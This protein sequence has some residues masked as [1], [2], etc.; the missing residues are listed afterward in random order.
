MLGAMRDVLPI[1]CRL[2]D[3]NLEAVELDVLAVDPRDP[4]QL[5][6]LASP[7][8][9]WLHKTTEHLAG[10][11]QYACALRPAA[12]TAEQVPAS[13]H[14]NPGVSVPMRRHGQ[15]LNAFV[16]RFAF[17]LPALRARVS[18]DHPE[19]GRRRSCLARLLAAAALAAHLALDRPDAAAWSV[20]LD[21]PL[22]EDAISSQA[23]YRG[24][25]AGLP[26]ELITSLPISKA[27]E[28]TA[29]RLCVSEITI[30]LAALAAE[31]NMT[32]AR[33]EAR[34]RVADLLSCIA[35]LPL[36][37]ELG[38]PRPR[39]LHKRAQQFLVREGI[40]SDHDQAQQRLLV[41]G[42]GDEFEARSSGRDGRLRQPSKNAEHQAAFR[43]KAIY[44]EHWGRVSAEAGIL[45]PATILA[46]TRSQ[47]HREALTELLQSMVA[48]A[49]ASSGLPGAVQAGAHTNM[50]GEGA[51]GSFA[52][53]TPKDS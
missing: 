52:A 26:V 41:I 27:A 43:G 37:D 16:M 31:G 6:S 9:A 23:A 48:A 44:L 25:L 11:G 30:G 50:A 45:S 15:A 14:Y 5:I 51:A 3:A 32:R 42:I 53:D 38:Q 36:D 22:G 40:C 35:S 17:A 21:P 2:V 49:G 39:K 28:R 7:H 47:R 1:L 18:L 12:C 10:T 29:Y 24:V 13:L 34:G 20:A 19:P 46:K 8:L 33:Y 4:Q